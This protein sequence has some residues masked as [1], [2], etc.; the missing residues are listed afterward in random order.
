MR[1]VSLECP[2]DFLR[3]YNG[4]PCVLGE[5][6]CVCEHMEPMCDYLI[7]RDLDSL[8]RP[9]EFCMFPRHRPWLK[10]K[11]KIHWIQP[12]RKKRSFRV[13]SPVPQPLESH[14]LSVSTSKILPTPKG[15]GSLSVISFT[16]TT[17]SPSCNSL[18]SLPLSFF[19]SFSAKISFLFF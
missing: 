9:H 13:K 5:S 1:D 3:R 17:T 19:F 15:R 16:N 12:S 7:L 14:D 4:C 18:F 8:V 2:F 10:I 6:I 11:R